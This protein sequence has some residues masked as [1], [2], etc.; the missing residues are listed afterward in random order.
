MIEGK[1]KHYTIGSY[2]TKAIKFWHRTLAQV[3]Y[4]NMFRNGKA[5]SSSKYVSVNGYMLNMLTDV[6]KILEKE[7]KRINNLIDNYK[8]RNNGQDNIRNDLRML[9][10]LSRQMWHITFTVRLRKRYALGFPQNQLDANS[11][12]TTNFL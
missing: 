8:P 2:C 12:R 10:L 1:R 5:S 4:P 9:I 11:S 3:D 6:E 7:E